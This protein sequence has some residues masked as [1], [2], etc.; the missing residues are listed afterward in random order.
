[1][2]YVSFVVEEEVRQD[3]IMLIIV[4]FSFDLLYKML[5]GPSNPRVCM[6]LIED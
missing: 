3:S 2:E 6:E 5:V 4:S 1:M